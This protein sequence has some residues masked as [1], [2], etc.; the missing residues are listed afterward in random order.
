MM[1]LIPEISLWLLL[2]FLLVGMMLLSLIEFIV[3]SITLKKPEENA[4]GLSPFGGLINFVFK[5]FS[6]LLMKLLGE[7]ANI[8][9]LAS[10]TEEDLRNWVEDRAS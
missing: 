5:P 4:I 2:L 9:T 8:V 10:M 1:V 3:E 7:N 6:T